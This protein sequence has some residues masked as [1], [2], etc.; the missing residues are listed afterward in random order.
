MVDYSGIKF[1]IAASRRHKIQIFPS[2]G[3]LVCGG[4]A[5]QRK[6][7][8]D[9]VYK[10]EFLGLL[11]IPDHIYPPLSIF[12]SQPISHPPQDIT[13]PQNTR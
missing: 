3:L 6:P 5:E 1:A 12:K 13:K 8:I 11:A 9:G 4:P 7:G 2:P 10:R